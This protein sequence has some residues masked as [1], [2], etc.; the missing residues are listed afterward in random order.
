[1]AQQAPASSLSS[2]DCGPE[3][4]ERGLLLAF[5]AVA[6]ICLM[7]QVGGGLHSVWTKCASQLHAALLEA[8][9]NL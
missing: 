8:S 3:V 9:H 2:Y 1:M 4:L 6:T 7:W 5:I